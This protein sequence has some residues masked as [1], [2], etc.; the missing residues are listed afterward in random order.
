MT[1]FYLRA[2]GITTVKNLLF[3]LM[4]VAILMTVAPH[5]PQAVLTAVFLFVLGLNTFLFSEWIFANGYLP[6]RALVITIVGT[7]IWDLMI[8]IGF[9]SW[10]YQQNMFIRQSAF[11]IFVP[12]A[13]HV[14]AMWMAYITRKRALA[15]GSSTEGLI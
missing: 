11:F 14:G 1:S 4:N 15:G 3:I 12:F 5:V 8:W 7:F 9:F 6:F 2:L 10:L 13:I